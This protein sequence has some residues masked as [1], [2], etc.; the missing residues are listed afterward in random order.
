MKREQILLELQMVTGIVSNDAGY[1][2][3]EMLKG[4]KPKEEKPKEEFEAV[5]NTLDDTPNMSLDDWFNGL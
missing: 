1:L 2:Y 3:H 5:A 4:G